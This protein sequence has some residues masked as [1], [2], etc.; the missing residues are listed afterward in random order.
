MLDFDAVLV[1]AL[2]DL[3][4]V[5]EPLNLNIRIR[6][7]IK[8][9]LLVSLLSGHVL[10]SLLEATWQWVHHQSGAILDIVGD[11]DLVVTGIGLASLSDNEDVSSANILS[12]NSLTIDFQC[13]AILEPL[14]LPSI[15]GKFTLKLARLLDVDLLLS[16]WLDY[17]RFTWLSGK[18]NLRARFRFRIFSGTTTDVQVLVFLRI[19]LINN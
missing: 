1:R 16:E 3:L 5:D 10:K 8:G 4:V 11:L 6:D 17:A 12:N 9:D 14:W 19:K 15:T 13:L 2:G 7:N 18:H